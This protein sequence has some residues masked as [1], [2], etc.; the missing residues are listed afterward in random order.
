MTTAH[1]KGIGRGKKSDN[2]HKKTISPQHQRYTDDNNVKVT[3]KHSRNQTLFLTLRRQSF[4]QNHGRDTNLSYFARCLFTTETLGKLWIRRILIVNTL[5]EYFAECIRAGPDRATPSRRPSIDRGACL[6]ASEFDF[7]VLNPDAFLPLGEPMPV[8]LNPPYLDAEHPTIS[9]GHRSNWKTYRYDT[10]T[11]KLVPADGSG[12][13]LKVTIRHGK[14]STVA[15]ILSADAKLE[16]ARNNTWQ[17]TDEV[18]ALEAAIDGSFITRSRM[19]ATG[20]W[21]TRLVRHL[22]RKTLL[23]RSTLYTLPDT[24]ADQHGA[25]DENARPSDNA[26][27]GRWKAQTKYPLDQTRTTTM[28]SWK[29]KRAQSP[30]NSISGWT[31]S[32]IGRP[33]CDGD[34]FGTAFQT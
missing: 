25:P 6:R 1:R 23:N 28:T 14:L 8:C 19:K 9:D 11:S 3:F 13:P 29:R 22:Q 26:G 18:L 30:S 20:M 4:K 24:V 31:N 34:R 12:T 7:F 16:H 27:D 21:V 17:L 5:T 15:V 2:E 33:P 10:K 32:R